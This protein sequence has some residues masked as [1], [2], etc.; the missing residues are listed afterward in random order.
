[1]T[2]FGPFPFFLFPGKQ[3]FLL[4]CFGVLDAADVVSYE[5]S[6]AAIHAAPFSISGYERIRIPR[7]G[8]VKELAECMRKSSE[9]RSR[10]CR[11]VD[12]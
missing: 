8:A 6:I 5:S 2:R 12:T 9:S 1:M 10:K 3:A 4:A 11:S 7:W